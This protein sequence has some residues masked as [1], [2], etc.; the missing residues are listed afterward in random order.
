MRKNTNKV[1][2]KVFRYKGQYVNYLNKVMDNPKIKSVYG[3]WSVAD[4][5]WVI[6][7]QYK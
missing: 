1:Y 4:K 3:M 7:Y 2:K 6:T 5:M